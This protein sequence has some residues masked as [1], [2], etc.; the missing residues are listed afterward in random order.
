MNTLPTTAQIRISNLG[1]NGGK[2]V[3]SIKASDLPRYLEILLD[4]PNGKFTPKRSREFD[5]L[6]LL[7]LFDL[8]DTGEEV[9]F[10][11]MAHL[12][13]KSVLNS[14]GDPLLN[15][16]PEDGEERIGIN[17]F[18]EFK[19]NNIVKPKKK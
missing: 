2:K 10:K 12:P 1:L 5:H 3:L 7:S 17:K 6:P 13:T 8:A 9:I 16:L 19:K 15:I 18:R 4:E 14:K 11:T